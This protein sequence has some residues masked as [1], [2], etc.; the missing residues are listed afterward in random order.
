M[1]LS[2]ES[3]HKMLPQPD[4]TCG[5]VEMVVAFVSILSVLLGDLNKFR[6]SIYLK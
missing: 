4:E 1:G 6:S 3:C 5:E 2:A